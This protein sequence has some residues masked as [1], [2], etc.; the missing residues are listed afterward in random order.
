VG[1]AA[2]MNARMC[3]TADSKT[4]VEGLEPVE[5]ITEIKAQEAQSKRSTQTS[6]L[7]SPEA[8]GHPG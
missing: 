2:D 1:K 5:V 7:H 4:N 8:A 3:K 6:W